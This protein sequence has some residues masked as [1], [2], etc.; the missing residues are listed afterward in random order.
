LTFSDKE[1]DKGGQRRFAANPAASTHVGLIVVRF[2]TMLVTLAALRVLGSKMPSHEFSAYLILLQLIGWIV[3]GGLIGMGVSVPRT[4]ASNRQSYAAESVLTT[5]AVIAI[6]MLALP[7]AALIAWPSGV[8]HLTFRDRTLHSVVT[9][10]ALFVLSLGPILLFMYY[11]LGLLQ[12]RIP[13]FIEFVQSGI[14]ALSLAILLARPLSASSF[15]RWY[16]LGNVALLVVL[17]AFA[18]RERRMRAQV[19]GSWAPRAAVAGELLNTGVPK[20]FSGLFL[21]FL[22]AA[23]P[24][25]MRWAGATVAQAA[26]AALGMSLFVSASRLAATSNALVSFMRMISHGGEDPAAARVVAARVVTVA[27]GFAVCIVVFGAGFG[28]LV[29]RVLVGPVYEHQGEFIN[30]GAALGGTY[31]AIYLL[32][33]PLDAL[34]S[35]WNKAALSAACAFVA[36]TLIVAGIA[37]GVLGPLGV[38]GCLFGAAVA[39]IVLLLALIRRLLKVGFRPTAKITLS[40]FG[41]VGAGALLG[42]LRVAN[43][44]LL[45]DL[46]C[47]ALAALAIG[48]LLL[49][50]GLLGLLF[51]QSGAVDVPESLPA[52]RATGC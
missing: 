37:T 38:A 8:A 45:W 29:V 36:S 4:I 43:E 31:F 30:I 20:F 39:T 9:A 49:W 5:A 12:F 16:S 3:A 15:L 22:G 14:L 23:L 52:E 11:F 2:A 21:L 32:E 26:A 48:G 34:A 27:I 40:L 19:R 33:V 44:A 6:A 50:S 25:G 35:I 51:V 28:D 7:I 41:S 46:L 18:R 1:K 42:L 10:G 47:A 24:V 13:V 17:L